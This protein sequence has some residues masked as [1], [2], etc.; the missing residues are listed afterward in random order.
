MRSSDGN[1]LGIPICW[2]FLRSRNY[3]PSAK[4][5]VQSCPRNHTE[6][7]KN[8]SHTLLGLLWAMNSNCGWKHSRAPCHPALF[9]QLFPSRAKCWA[10]CSNSDIKQFALMHTFAWSRAFST[11]LLHGSYYSSHH[12]SVTAE[13]SQGSA[14]WKNTVAVH[15]PALK[16]VCASVCVCVCVCVTRTFLFILPLPPRLWRL[17]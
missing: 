9:P 16:W 3:C 14:C 5:A 6:R 15:L 2:S 17:A 4:R 8:T 12:V 1:G 7:M 10:Y 11:D 13:P